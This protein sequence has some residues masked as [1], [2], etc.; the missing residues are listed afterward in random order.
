MHWIA[1]NVLSAVFG[2]AVTKLW[3]AYWD[4][5]EYLK[6]SIALIFR[7]NERIRL[8]CAYLF[9]IKY[10]NKYLLIKG[11]RIDQYQPVGGVYK[12]YQ[13]FQ[14]TCNELGVTSEKEKSFY[15]K[16]DLRVYV[17]G[18]DVMRF[19]K[20]FNTGEGR[21]VNVT[22]E[23]YEELIK[24]GFLPLEALIN[25]QFEYIKQ[26]HGRLHDSMAFQC[27]EVLLHNVYEV[28]L[29]EEYLDLLQNKI[30]NGERRIIFVEQQDIEKEAVHIDDLDIKIGAHT[31][32]IM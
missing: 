1:N 17:L 23:F 19:I 2:V 18:K 20:W 12:T 9:R 24:P 16:N 7:R 22:R 11:N 4:N 31:K 3:D 30:N 14:K 5:K 15:E 13:S 21:E 26:E 29:G 32:R 25:A 27:K 28:V 8:S 10:R 6:L